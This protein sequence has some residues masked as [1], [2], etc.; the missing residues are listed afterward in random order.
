M[1]RWV[2][3]LLVLFAVLGALGGGFAIANALTDAPP[4]R[5]V[6]VRAT[7]PVLQSVQELA[8]L[9]TVSFRIERVVQ[10]KEEQR[11]AFGLLT[12]EDSI[13][14]VAAADVS[15][16]VD[17]RSLNADRVEVDD[18][19]NRVRLRLPAPAVFTIALDEERTF[20]HSRNTDLLAKPNVA[21]ESQARRAALSELREAALASGILARAEAGA[22]RT[23]TSLL[24]ALG[25]QHVEIHFDAP[26]V[27][28]GAPRSD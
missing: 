19:N 10:L 3:V 17:L 9:E 24:M 1:P 25:Y 6:T 22:K 15:A 28:A 23:L 16:G 11:R 5:V 21:L 7:P 20:V 4:E 2:V 13:L 27:D 12:A 8:R 18:A 26:A 14:L